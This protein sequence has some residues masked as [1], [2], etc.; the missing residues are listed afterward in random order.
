MVQG[1]Q[2]LVGVSIPALLVL[3]FVLAVILLVMGYR[4]KNLPDRANSFFRA[5]LVLLGAMTALTPILWYWT[6]AM[7]SGTLL[8][9]VLDIFILGLGAL[10]GGIVIGVGFVFRLRVS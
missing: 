6:W 9:S 1:T 2:F 10:L 4:E 3:G 7:P 8:M 5:G